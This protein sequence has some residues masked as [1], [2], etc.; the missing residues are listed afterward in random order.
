MYYAIISSYTNK[1]KRTTL[2]HN[3]QHIWS[4]IKKNICNQLYEIM[5]RGLVN[6]LND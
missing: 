6:E 5:S 1:H 2:Q 3:A 4:Y